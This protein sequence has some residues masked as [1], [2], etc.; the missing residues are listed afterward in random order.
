MYREI[1]GCMERAGIYCLTLSSPCHAVVGSRNPP[2][3]PFGTSITG[4]A[5]SKVYFFHK[6][7]VIYVLC[8]NALP[9]SYAGLVQLVKL[10]SATSAGSA[11][12]IALPHATLHNNALYLS[13]QGLAFSKNLDAD[14]PW[15]GKRLYHFIL[16]CCVRARAMV[17]D[18]FVRFVK[19]QTTSVWYI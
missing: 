6:C 14:V 16:E 18:Y 3:T 9:G 8:C 7:G 19:I 17:N 10:M 5:H 11:F 12:T 2:P 15:G 4:S 13:S 1:S